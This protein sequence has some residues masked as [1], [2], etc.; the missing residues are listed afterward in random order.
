[1]RLKV[2]LLVSVLLV[3]GLTTAFAGNELRLGTAGAQELRIPIGSRGTAMGGAVVANTY[4]IESVYWNPAGLASLR[5]TEAMFTHLPYIAD[6]NVNFG[7]VGTH[8]EDF[9]TIAFAAKVVSIGD[10]EET[11]EEFPNGTGRVFAPSMVVLGISYARELTANVSFGFTGNLVSERIFEVSASGMSFDFG[12]IYQPHWRG[13]TLGL[14]IKNFGPQMQFSGRG[15]EQNNEGHQ[16]AASASSFD[17]P[18][19]LNIGLSYDLMN[20]GMN[21]ALASGNF[22][23]NNYSQDLWQGGFEYTYNELYA[24]RAGYNYSEQTDYLYG[25]SFGGGLKVDVSG[26]MLSF[27]YSWTETDVFNANQY[28]T[29]KAHF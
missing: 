13:L 24:I 29:V 8:I 17:L 18:T 12:F 20:E 10:M 11:T 4:G 26:T 27:D 5:G 19:S 25:F 21:H 6:I 1:M 23:S 15:F 9:G 2:I 28:F 16:T 7:G 22:R 3:T 14:A